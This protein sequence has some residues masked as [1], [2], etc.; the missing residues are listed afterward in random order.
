MKTWPTEPRSTVLTEAG[1]TMVVAFRRHML[2][3]LDDCLC[4][5][6]PSIRI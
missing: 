3:R 6:Q 5:L 4:A 1:E 2:L